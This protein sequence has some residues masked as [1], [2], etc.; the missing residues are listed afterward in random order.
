MSETTI[1]SG[2]G[3][4]V[5][6]DEFGS[7]AIEG[8]W[9][10]VQ[11]PNAS[12]DAIAAAHLARKFPHQRGTVSDCPE[13]HPA[14]LRALTERLEAAEDILVE[15]R[16]GYWLSVLDEVGEA[17]STRMGDWVREY[18]GKAEADAVADELAAAVSSPEHAPPP[19][20]WDGF[21]PRD[22][23]GCDAKGAV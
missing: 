10:T 4:R 13:A 3:W 23:E 16:S 14:E 22:P 19:Q 6:Q 7:V 15:L 11:L 2:A 8:F 17:N 20:S 21:V 9:S 18:W 1:A 5:Y 12:L